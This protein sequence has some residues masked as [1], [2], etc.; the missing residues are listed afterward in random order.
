METYTL[1]SRDIPLNEEYDVIVAGGGPAGCTAAAAAARE[2][3]KTLLIE[4]TGAL[5]GMGTL[6]LVPAWCPFSDKERIIYGGMAEEVFTRTKEGMPHVQNDEMDWV[7]ID[8][9]L[10]KRIY[11]DL[12]TENGADILFNTVFSAVDADQTGTVQT[13]IVSNK[14]GL[15]AYK[16]DVFIDC[17]GDADL[18]TWAGADFQKG[19]PDTGDMQPATHCF[20]I[21]NVDVYGYEYGPRFQL[22]GENV[23]LQMVKDK[24]YPLIVDTHRCNSLIGP[25][26]VGFNTGHIY[27][28][29]NTDPVNLSHALIQGRQLASQY[30]DALAEYLPQS[31]GNGFLVNTGSLLG[32]RETRRVIGDYILTIDDYLERKSF[33]DEICRNAYYIDIHFSKKDRE[34][35]DAGKLDI[36]KRNLRYNP[37]E[38]HGIPYRCL[39]PKDL[40]NVLVAGRSISTDRRVQGST[41][42]M[43]VCLAMGEAA[44]IAAAFA[45][46]A[47]ESNV[48]AVD[49]DKL[50][51]RLKDTGAYLP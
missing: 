36:E 42:V 40:T 22:G 25:G 38:S 5:G 6:G 39:T 21:A 23:P 1:E 9:E 2:G 28:V 43:P 11:D 13:I 32:I 37:G 24:K 16:A 17:T 15:T 12:V 19:D 33:S 27:D 31:F 34:K 35:F 30:R 41:R 48:H 26:C 3:V 29:D 14:A 44:G 47:E 50:R 4:A 10:L 20:V 46:A 51:Q 7:G 8:P 18:C 45:S 49:T